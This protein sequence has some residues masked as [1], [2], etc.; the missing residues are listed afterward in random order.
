[1]DT[2]ISGIPVQVFRTYDTTD[3]RLGDFGIGWRISLGSYR[4]TPNNKLGQG[5]WSTEPFGFPFTRFR[6]KTTVPHFVTVTSPGGRVEVFDLVP[7]P[8]GPLLSLTTPEFVPR[9]GTGTTSKLEDADPPTLSLAGTSL[10]DF[11]GGTIYDP[12]L[13]RLT[14]KDGIVLIID[15]FGGLKSITDRN[16]NKA[17]RLVRWRDLAVDRPPSHVRA[18]R[19]RADHRDPRRGRE[20]HAVRLLGCGRP[21]HLHGREWRV[22]AFTYNGSHRLLTVDGPGDTRVRTLTYG[23]DGRITSI[24]DGAGNTTSLSSDV[25]ARSEITT[26]PS[27]RLTTFF[28]YG[29]DGNLATQ[30]EVFSG[31]SRV[32]SYEYDAEGRVTKTTSPLG[33]VETL[34]YDAAGNIT[35]RTT[36]KNEKWTYA[37]NAFNEPT[38]TTGPDGSVVESYTYDAKGNLTSVNLRDGTA[39]TFTNDSRG[40]PATMTDAFGTTSFAYDADQQLTSETDPAGGIT[41]MTYD[42][43][44]RLGVIREPGRRGHAGQLELPRQAGGPDRGKRIDADADVRR[45]WSGRVVHGQSEPGRPPTSTTRKVGS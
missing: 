33:R 19:R 41:R 39:A 30:E 10:A 29:A 28:K 37:F 34:T 27:G 43:A 26:S 3:R 40:L 16:G 13:F 42:T 9:P 24:T 15:R 12:T 4:A 23:P 44:G 31:H 21:P 14:T 20:A 8:S 35:S 25:D 17:D 1:M 36:P 2:E 6:F 7:A 18:R 5:G 11:F 38:T 32:T 22:D 45:V